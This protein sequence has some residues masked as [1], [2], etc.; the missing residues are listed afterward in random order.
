MT[1]WVDYL[2]KLTFLVNGGHSILSDGRSAVP[3]IRGK[4]PLFDSV[5]LADTPWEVMGILVGSGLSLF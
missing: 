1:P 4:V 5:Q 2:N 3:G